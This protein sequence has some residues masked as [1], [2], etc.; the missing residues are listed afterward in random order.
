MALTITYSSDE[1]PSAL[2]AFN[3]GFDDGWNGRPRQKNR[4]AQ[5]LRSYRRARIL[6]EEELQG[7]VDIAPSRR[8]RSR[9]A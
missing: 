1:E 7:G 2:Q 9:R 5:Y 3:D 6:R 4:G 8:S